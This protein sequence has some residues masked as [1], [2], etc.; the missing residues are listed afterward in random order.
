[1][2]KRQRIERIEKGSNI[3]IITLILA[4]IFRITGLFDKALITAAVLIVCVRFVLIPFWWAIL[5]DTEE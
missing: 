1:M 3:A 5:N 2:R 4:A